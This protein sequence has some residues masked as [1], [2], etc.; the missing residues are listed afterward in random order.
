MLLRTETD[1][2]AVT[3]SRDN[4]ATWSEPALT[5]YTDC[6]C[7]HHFGRLPDGRFFGL[8]CPEPRSRR[9]PLVLAA[10][11]DGVV[12]D[13][14]YVLGDEPADQP[15][16]DGIFKFGRYGYPSYCFVEGNLHVIYSV[17]KEDIC[18]VRVP[19]DALS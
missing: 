12:F 15:R 8:S 18:T 17:S 9:T 7:R 11:A 14:H 19:L 13:R 4:G 16:R 5:D 1:H 10:S 3:E 2:L 6:M